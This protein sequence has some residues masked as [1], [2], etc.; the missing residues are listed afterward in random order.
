MAVIPNVPLLSDRAQQVTENF[1]G[2]QVVLFEHA[3]QLLAE[4]KLVSVTERPLD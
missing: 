1:L 4:N 3:E 2:E